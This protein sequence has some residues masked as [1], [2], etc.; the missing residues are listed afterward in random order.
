MPIIH[1]CRIKRKAERIKVVPQITDGLPQDS[2]IRICQKRQEVKTVR[3]EHPDS[4]F[5]RR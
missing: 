2:M 5:C 4:L 3:D 1:I